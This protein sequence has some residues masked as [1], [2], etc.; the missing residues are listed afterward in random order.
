MAETA[1]LDDILTAVRT[2]ADEQ[3]R[4]Q[5]S[6][7][8]R[9]TALEQRMG[10]DDDGD[11]GEEG[12]RETGANEG[13][14]EGDGGERETEGN[15]G[16]RET[17]ANEGEREGGNDGQRGERP[18]TRAEIRRAARER[19]EQSRSERYGDHNIRPEG[20]GPSLNRNGFEGLSVGTWCAAS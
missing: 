1:T 18:M 3:N 17:G 19:N 4:F 11:D 10:D 5:N 13:E 2:A 16:E 9:L 20:S 15:E 12:E 7:E 14:R 8:V 6:I